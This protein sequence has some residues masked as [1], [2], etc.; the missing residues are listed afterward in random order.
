LKNEIASAICFKD[1]KRIN[2]NKR[3]SK[4]E[5]CEYLIFDV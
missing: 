2:K 3:G 5:M 4:L 1:M